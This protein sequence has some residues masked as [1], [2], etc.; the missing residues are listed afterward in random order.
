MDKKGKIC[1]DCCIVKEK[2]KINY[3]LFLFIGDENEKII[4]ENKK[5]CSYGDKFKKKKTE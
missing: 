4:I 2:A 1:Y 3:F 5:N